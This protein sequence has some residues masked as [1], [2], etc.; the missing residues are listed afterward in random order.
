MNILILPHG[1][2]RTA[3]P[4]PRI[5]QITVRILNLKM[6]MGPIRKSRATYKGQCITSLDGVTKRDLHRMLFKVPI[7]PF[8]LIRMSNYYGVTHCPIDPFQ[9][10]I[11]FSIVSVNDNTIVN[12]V[13]EDPSVNIQDY[14]CWFVT[15]NLHWGTDIGIPTFYHMDEMVTPVWILL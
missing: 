3:G 8:S 10:P 5:Y 12:Y 4:R 7:E 15:Y 6:K 2:I 9:L 11:E 14:M 13:D 1:L